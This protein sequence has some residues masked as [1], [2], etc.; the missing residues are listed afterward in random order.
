MGGCDFNRGLRRSAKG[1]RVGK[2]CRL[3]DLGRVGACGGARR[4]Y[5]SPPAVALTETAAP[6][7]ATGICADAGA[8][9]AVLGDLRVNTPKPGAPFRC[10][11]GGVG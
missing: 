5:R 3:M 9:T 2:R 7:R 10:P 1:A 8:E 6:Q 11:A 4:L